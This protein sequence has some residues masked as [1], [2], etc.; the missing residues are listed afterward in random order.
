M[1]GA[2]SNVPFSDQPAQECA[3]RKKKDPGASQRTDP[4][5]FFLL[6]AYRECSEQITASLR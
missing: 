6:Q 5:V 3:R 4:R 2:F 1:G